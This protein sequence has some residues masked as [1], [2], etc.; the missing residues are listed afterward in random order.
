MIGINIEVF[1][2]QKLRE[3]KL[4]FAYLNFGIQYRV[5]AKLHTNVCSDVITFFS[6]ECDFFLLCFI[7][8]E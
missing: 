2:M 1:V 7:V 4:L 3:K 5:D 6:L 8:C